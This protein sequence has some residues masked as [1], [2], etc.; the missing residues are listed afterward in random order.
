MTTSTDSFTTNCGFLC[1]VIALTNGAPALCWTMSPSF[2]VW[3][4]GRGIELHGDLPATDVASLVQ[5]LHVAYH[6]HRD[7]RHG[8]RTEAVMRSLIGR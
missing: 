1:R 4:I 3:A 2:A 8:V 6:V 7:L 5:L